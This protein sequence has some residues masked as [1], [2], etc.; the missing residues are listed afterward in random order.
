[1]ANVA[2]GFFSKKSFMVLAS[3]SR[4]ELKSLAN[5]KI[6]TG[7]GIPGPGTGIPGEPGIGIP[8]VV[9]GFGCLP[10]IPG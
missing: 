8:G 9:S 6:G 2:L 5:P 3:L 10:G 7:I 4:P 1:M